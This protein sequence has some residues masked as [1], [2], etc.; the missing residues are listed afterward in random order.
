MREGMANF[1]EVSA[2][3]GGMEVHG[4]RVRE[5]QKRSGNERRL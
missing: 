3:G 5:I 4:E 2:G 1:R